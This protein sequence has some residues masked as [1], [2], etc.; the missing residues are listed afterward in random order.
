VAAAIF[1]TIIDHGFLC[2]PPLE[3]PGYTWLPFSRHTQGDVLVVKRDLLPAL[4]SG[5]GAAAKY[6]SGVRRVLA[7]TLGWG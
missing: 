4:W 7:R 6:G 1:R 2:A 5:R 3:A